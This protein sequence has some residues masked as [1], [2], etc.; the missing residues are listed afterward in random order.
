VVGDVSA[1]IGPHNLDL[2]SG[3]GGFVPQQVLLTA[4]AA[5]GERVWMLEQQQSRG[6]L[7]ASD[8]GGQALLHLPR[9]S[10]GSHSEVD[11]AA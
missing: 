1:T 7:A 8:P 5:E 11:D 4:A 9:L 2:S 10:I 3:A 6:L